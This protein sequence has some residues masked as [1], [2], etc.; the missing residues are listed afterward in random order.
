[1][2]SNRRESLRKGLRKFESDGFIQ[3]L[4]KVIVPRIYNIPKLIK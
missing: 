1:M 3:Y 4:D 2:K